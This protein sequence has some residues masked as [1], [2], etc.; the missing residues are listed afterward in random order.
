MYH[1]VHITD[2][3]VIPHLS[4]VFPHNISAEYYFLML[5]CLS[6]I[7]KVIRTYFEVITK[8][9]SKLRR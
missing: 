5:K 4:N 6:I 2:I 9:L 8:L 3:M 1:G 7:N